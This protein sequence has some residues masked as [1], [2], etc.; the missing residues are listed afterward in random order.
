MQA[1]IFTQKLCMSHEPLSLSMKSVHPGLPTFLC[2]EIKVWAS[3]ANRHLLHDPTL[4]H[5]WQYTEDSAQG[6]AFCADRQQDR[7]TQP[8]YPLPLLRFWMLWVELHACG[9]APVLWSSQQPQPMALQLPCIA[10][11]LLGKAGCWDLIC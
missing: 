2:A 3:E 11:K 8:L 10:E 9:G 7:V 1:C 4:F 6:G 5:S